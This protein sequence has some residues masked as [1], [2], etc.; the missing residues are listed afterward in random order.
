VYFEVTL[1]N[2]LLILKFG[3]EKLALG[4]ESSHEGKNR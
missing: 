2:N 4:R 3:K 1:E